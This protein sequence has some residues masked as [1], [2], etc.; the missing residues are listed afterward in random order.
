D[1]A[2]GVGD[3]PAVILVVG[4]DHDDDVGPVGQRRLVARLLVAAVA[5]VLGVLQDRQAHLA[6]DLDGAVGAAVVHQ[7]D[8][9]HRAGG[10]GGQRGGG[11]ALGVVGRH[12]GD[13]LVLAPGGGLVGLEDAIDVEDL[14]ARPQIGGLQ[15]RHGGSNS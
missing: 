13:D 6:G 15:Q 9:V 7:A 4:V 5:A 8:L 14:M 10:D 11:G 1:D 2:D 12:D 3:D